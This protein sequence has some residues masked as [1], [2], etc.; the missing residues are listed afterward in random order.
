MTRNFYSRIVSLTLLIF[1]LSVAFSLAEVSP[2][3]TSARPYGMGSAFG[4]I[5][6]DI[7]A[8][9]FNPSG[10]A[11]QKQVEVTGHGGRS[12]EE[13][14]AA[15]SELMAA[16]ILPLNIY[17]ETWKTG[18]LGFLLHRTGR[19]RD[20]SITNLSV[21]A[22]TPLK[23]IVPKVLYKDRIPGRI[24]SGMSFRIRQI[25]RGGG[26]GSDVGIGL[27]MGFLYRFP[28]SKII[29]RNGWTTA[30]VIQE[31]N[32]KSISGGVLW[33]L[34]AAWRYERY[35]L[36]MDLVS[37]NGVSKFFPGAE[38]ALFKKLILLRVGT[39]HEPGKS[40]QITLGLGT[41]MPP[42]QMDLAYGLPIGELKRANDR[43][44]FTFT[45]R[46]GTPFLSQYLRKHKDEGDSKIRQTI[47]NLEIKK[48]TLEEEIEQKKGLYKKVKSGLEKDKKRSQKVKEE[49][50]LSEEE[51]EAKKDKIKEM[52]KEIRLLQEEKDEAIREIQKI[53]NIKKIPGE[54]KHLH[55]V[56]KGESLR[57]L[58]EKYYGDPDK[59]K[60]IYDANEGKVIRGTPIVGEEIIIP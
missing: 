35:T 44:L 48:S 37:H 45:Y 36:A 4:A 15:Q 24:Y 31:M 56:R 17:R 53:K 41:L 34:A 14:S 19:S 42:I 13:G 9:F 47:T 6:N 46:F 2:L 11:N 43:I 54:K 33:R 5:A 50:K 26:Q 40:R 39:G 25:D 12:L 30:L 55:K 10:L 58:A 8:I 27:D 18:T 7:N 23:K 59:W 16:G 51:L 29:W 49:L 38:V 3:P 60:L 1:L 52:W 20:D 57:G 32:T 22:G 28:S 21:S